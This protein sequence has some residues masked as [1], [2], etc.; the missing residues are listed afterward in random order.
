MSLYWQFSAN[1]HINWQREEIEKIYRKIQR[2][3]EIGMELIS[4]YQT[5]GHQDRINMIG[6][7]IVDGGQKWIDSHP[8]QIEWLESIGMT[9]EE[10]VDSFKDWIG[11]VRSKFDNHA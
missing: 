4:V 7:A 9:A 8:Q 6:S 5:V 2:L 1:S 10:A 11:D 3:A